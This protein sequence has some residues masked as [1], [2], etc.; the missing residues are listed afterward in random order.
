MCAAMPC[1]GGVSEGEKK[2]TDRRER[3]RECL[4]H[5]VCVRVCVRERERG[6]KC[7]RGVRK[8]F[9]GLQWLCVWVKLR[10]SSHHLISSQFLISLTETEHTHTHT[11]APFP[12]PLSP[13]SSS[14]SSFIL[15]QCCVGDRSEPF[16]FPQ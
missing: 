4:C 6:Y 13:Q 12:F 10:R 7:K 8:M 3:E 5:C 15:S 9:F 2:E 16:Q 1:V 11:H 14:L